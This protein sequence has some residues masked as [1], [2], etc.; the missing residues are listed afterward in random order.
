MSGIARVGKTKKRIAM[1]GR[2]TMR[3]LMLATI[4]EVRAQRQPRCRGTNLVEPTHLQ[5][6]VKDVVTR[7]LD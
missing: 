3:R 5:L 7:L 6:V 2:T 4:Q 1:R